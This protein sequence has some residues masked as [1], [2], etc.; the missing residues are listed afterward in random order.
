LR[1][2]DL[3]N[4]ATIALQHIDAGA[5]GAIDVAEAG[6]AIPFSI[7]RVYTISGIADAG[8]VRGRHAHHA[9]E[10]AIFCVHGSCVMDLDDGKQETS[11]TLSSPATGVYVGPHLWHV[12]REFSADAVVLVLASQLYEEADYIRDYADFQRIVQG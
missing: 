10:Q 11:V 8:T 4:C 12:L 9:L 7:A 2:D 1:P 3:A 5:A 6:R